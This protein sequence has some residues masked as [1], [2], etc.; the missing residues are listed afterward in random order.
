MS[1]YKQKYKYYKYKYLKLTGGDSNRIKVKI[2][3]MDRGDDILIDV[4]NDANVG[5]I[6]DILASETYGI[7]KSAQTLTLVE[8][9][10]DPNKIK[11]LLDNIM[12]NSLTTFDDGLGD[13]PIITMVLILKVMS[14]T[15]ILLEI[16]QENEFI[17]ALAGWN[18]ST[19]LKDWR[20]ITVENGNVTKLKIDIGLKKLPECIGGLKHLTELNL[21]NAHLFR[22]PDNIQY[23]T[24]LTNLKLYNIQ[25]T[26]LP[27]CICRLPNLEKLDLSWNQL[28]DLPHNLGNL[29]KLKSLTLYKNLLQILPDSIGDLANLTRLNCSS[30]NLSTLPNSIGNL[31]NL[32]TLDC[33]DNNFINLPDSIAKLTNLESLELEN[34]FVNSIY[35]AASLDTISDLT[36]LKR[37]CIEKNGI[38]D[39]PDSISKLTKLEVLKLD[40]NNLTTLPE[41]I[42]TLTNLEL[43]NIDFNYLTTIPY[44]VCNLPHLRGLSIEH[45]TL[46]TLP[47]NF[48]N[49]KKSLTTLYLG[50]NRLTSLPRSF[51]VNRDGRLLLP[52]LTGTIDLKPNPWF[53]KGTY[54]GQHNVSTTNRQY[55]PEKPAE[56]LPSITTDDLVSSKTEDLAPSMFGDDDDY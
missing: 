30:N 4:K 36:N 12:V 26:R 20:S 9:D 45:N 24:S 3:R 25:L 18:R 13:T 43:L 22:I 33:S 27:S 5:T 8:N 50:W 32:D 56:V 16:K 19:P 10:L 37:L 1:D 46:E 17:S 44:S 35:F 49:L 48:G 52:Y 40:Y 53:P 55:K 28:K 15:D 6:K 14:D 41:F 2:I 42:G 7:L 38:Y 31:T 29:T 39:L 34:S 23:L 47:D 21:S 51:A 11:P 54:F